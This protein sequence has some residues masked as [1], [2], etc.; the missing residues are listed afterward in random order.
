VARSRKKKRSLWLKRLLLFVFVPFFIWFLAFL[1]WFNWS[2][3]EKLTGRAKTQT[4]ATGNSDLKEEPR[5]NAEPP[6]VR[7]Q[8][9][10]QPEPAAETPP[11][12]K[13]LD[14]DRKKLE[15]ILK[16]Q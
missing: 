7:D 1:I 5:D 14:E 10:K 8:P 12:E 13:I 15:D 9:S 16:K 11:K 6:D 4:K 3:L 2:S